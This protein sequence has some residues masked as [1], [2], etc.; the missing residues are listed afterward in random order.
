MILVYIWLIDEFLLCE[1]IL[2]KYVSPD[3]VICDY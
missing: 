1:D 2:T 3:G